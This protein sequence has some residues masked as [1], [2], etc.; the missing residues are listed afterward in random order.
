MNK[1][2]IQKYL[3]S[4]NN[5]NELIGYLKEQKKILANNLD[6]IKI[7]DDKCF[8]LIFRLIDD[9]SDKVKYYALILL[10]NMGFTFNPNNFSKMCKISVDNSISVDGNVR[11]ANRL[12]IKEIDSFMFFLPIYTHFN[13]V[14]DKDI[15]IFYESFRDIFYGLYNNYYDEEYP[16]DEDTELKESLSKSLAIILPR[17]YEMAKFHRDRNELEMISELPIKITK[18]NTLRNDAKRILK[19]V[20]SRTLKRYGNLK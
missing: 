9:S 4:R 7:S 13:D 1:D 2:I 10:S 5:E 16:E 17:I 8:R 11:Y 20:I 12:L 18:G 15:S 6:L 19:K 14:S 3:D